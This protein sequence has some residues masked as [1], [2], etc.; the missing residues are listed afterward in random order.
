MDHEL[1]KRMAWKYIWWKTP[2]AAMAF[3][4]RI[5]AQVM[6]IGDFDDVRELTEAVGDDVLRQVL[7]S[8]EA[9]EFNLRSWCYWH[10]RLGL[11]ELGTVPPLP[12]RRFA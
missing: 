4:H 5:M 1:L 3:P 8:A 12:Q 10:Y 6:N 7:S 11:A 2:E 9:G